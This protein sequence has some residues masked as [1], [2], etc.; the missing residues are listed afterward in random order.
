MLRR[1]KTIES[2]EEIENFDS[3]QDEQ[4]PIV[5]LFKNAGIIV[6]FAGSFGVPF[7]SYLPSWS[8]IH[9]DNFN[10][11]QISIPKSQ[12]FEEVTKTI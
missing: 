6:K 1:V 9:N 2:D 3:L 11:C 5:S 12:K 8:W 4:Q 7:I 10:T